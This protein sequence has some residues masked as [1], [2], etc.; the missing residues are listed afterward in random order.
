MKER[1]KAKHF[2]KGSAAGEVPTRWATSVKIPK[3]K[4]SIFSTGG[5]NARIYFLPGSRAGKQ[6]PAINLWRN[7]VAA[8]FPLPAVA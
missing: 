2:K 8:H 4:L 3:Q 6:K 1:S 5:L 7:L